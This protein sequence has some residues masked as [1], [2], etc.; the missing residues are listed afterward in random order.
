[1]TT[2]FI[3]SNLSDRDK[4]INQNVLFLFIKLLYIILIIIKGF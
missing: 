3:I 2:N 1:M 4:N